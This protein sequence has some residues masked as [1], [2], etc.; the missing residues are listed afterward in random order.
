MAP[1][2]ARR[3]TSRNRTIVKSHC[4]G[5]HN[6]TNLRK[7]VA[8]RSH[9]ALPLQTKD[10]PR[11]HDLYV[12]ESLSSSLMAKES[13]STLSTDSAIS[14][15]GPLVLCA[16]SEDLDSIFNEQ[17]RLSPIVGV[18]AAAQT[19]LQPKVGSTCGTIYYHRL[20]TDDGEAISREDRIFL[21]KLGGKA[22]TL[23]RSTATRLRS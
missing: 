23:F 12:W 11:F 22:T 18:A 9:E 20:Y 19:V 4:T 17:S 3:Q 21:K 7:S 14:L 1:E 6:T 10:L 2:P 15:C 5:S 8:N 13:T 16:Q